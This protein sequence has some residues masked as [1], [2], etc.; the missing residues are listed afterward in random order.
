MWDNFLNQIPLTGSD[1]SSALEQQQLQRVAQAAVAAVKLLE[2]SNTDISIVSS[3]NCDGNSGP[4]HPG[5]LGM[6]NG[7]S[8]NVDASEMSVSLNNSSN[9]LKDVDLIKNIGAGSMDICS[10]ANQHA[11]MNPNKFTVKLSGPLSKQI[12]VI[13]KNCIPPNH[14][15][16]GNSL[17]TSNNY[18]TKIN[19][20]PS[21]QNS[22]D[23]LG[24]S[25]NFDQSQHSPINNSNDDENISN[26]LNNS[27]IDVTGKHAGD[28]R[29][30]SLT[31]VSDS[32]ASKIGEN[33]NYSLRSS[34][35]SCDTYSRR[36][37]HGHEH[38]KTNPVEESLLSNDTAAP[39]SQ[40]TR[41]E[42]TN[43]KC[44]TS[45]ATLLYKLNTLVALNAQLLKT[46]RTLS[47]QN[48]RLRKEKQLQS[49]AFLNFFNK[50]QI[51]AVQKKSTRGWNWSPQTIANALKLKN[52][53][54][55]A[56]YEEILR[57][58][59]PMPSL[60]TL[61]RRIS[62]LNSSNPTKN[63]SASSTSHFVTPNDNLHRSNSS[64]AADDPN[65]TN[66]FLSGINS[67]NNVSDEDTTSKDKLVLPV[68][69]QDLIFNSTEDE[70]AA[71][72]DDLQEVSSPG[73]INDDKP[74]M[75]SDNM[76]PNMDISPS[77]PLTL[78]HQ[79]SSAEVVNVRN[80]VKFDLDPIKL[81]EPH[82]QI[83][84]SSGSDQVLPERL[85][86]ALPNLLIHVNE[87]TKSTS[88][89]ALP[90]PI[91]L[92]DDHLTSSDLNKLNMPSQHCKT[93]DQIFG[94]SNSVHNKKFA[95]YQQLQRDA[96]FQSA[97]ES[98]F[99]SLNIESSQNQISSLSSMNFLSNF[100]L[101]TSP[102]MISYESMNSPADRP[103]I[104]HHPNKPC[105]FMLDDLAL[106]NNRSNKFSCN[107][108]IPPDILNN[109]VPSLAPS[110]SD[111]FNS[112]QPLTDVLQPLHDDAL[113]PINETALEPMD[114][115][116]LPPFE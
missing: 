108:L 59:F 102:S 14:Q 78:Q 21:K 105:K 13:K 90:S 25:E 11:I 89:H 85:K 95:P 50:D 73:N 58:R 45:K 39:S 33:S 70:F 116:V 63:K 112:L 23:L 86:T 69:M 68:E 41:N 107:S 54:G 91:S 19:F 83:V 87:V 88:P 38:L 27:T 48:L 43:T 103:L 99:E 26:T 9:S 47:K 36:K 82:R 110:L 28:S 22:F 15:S 66:E 84:I 16:N 101:P 113:H 57:Q 6:H 8:N 51:E 49:D 96:L 67:T 37:A 75:F 111:G 20:T 18:V 12:L 32:V 5:R 24:I 4:A 3:A 74:L 80:E 44:A 94:A 79:T 98:L 93:S 62:N 115:D 52:V 10:V 76:S 61:Q 71:A 100:S 114:E 31:G 42:C 77:S 64:N 81:C 7:I 106:L 30:A 46:N 104:G 35:Y 34:N 40:R 29:A 65:L 17:V 56:G 60:R 53:C 92:L 55:I 2:S 1:D 72:I 97:G 109:T